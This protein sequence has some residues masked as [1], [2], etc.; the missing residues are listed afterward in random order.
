MCNIYTPISFSIR[1]DTDLPTEPTN[2]GMVEH[3]R[4]S[5]VLQ[6]ENPTTGNTENHEEHT[7]VQEMSQQGY[8][9]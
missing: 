5:G 4:C 7:P 3:P 6:D 1:S 9:R 8:L 2:P